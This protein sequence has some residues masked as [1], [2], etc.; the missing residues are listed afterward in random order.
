MELFYW[1]EGNHEVDFVLQEGNRVTGIEVKSGRIH[2]AKG[3]AEFDKRFK[4]D[5][6][7]LVGIDGIPVGDFLMTG[8]ADL[9]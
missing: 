9:C 2:N 8:I 7:L 5:K 4:P 3:M 6:L 1:R